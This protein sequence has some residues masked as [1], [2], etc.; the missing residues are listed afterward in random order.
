MTRSAVFTLLIYVWAFC[1]L[2]V[3][4]SGR[5]TALNTLT[6]GAAGTAANAPQSSVRA[7]DLSVLPQRPQVFHNPESG[8]T[9]AYGTLNG[10]ASLKLR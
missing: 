9:A 3:A 1:S 5:E 6:G 7:A 10:E 4:A 8:G 2:F